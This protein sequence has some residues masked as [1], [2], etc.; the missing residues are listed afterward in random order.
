[1][2]RLLG[3][4]GLVCFVCGI[5]V[6]WLVDWNPEIIAIPVINIALGL[7]FIIIWFF[8][9]G[10][11]LFRGEGK[12]T[13]V[14]SAKLLSFS[15][16]YFVIVLGVIGLLNF[17]VSKYDWNFDLTRERIHT[18][19][20]KTV[21]LAKKI[22]DELEVVIPETEVTKS[23]IPFFRDMIEQINKHTDKVKLLVFNPY[24]KQTL[25]KDYEI[26]RGDAGVLVLRKAQ[27]DGK[28]GIKKVKLAS[29]TEA[30]FTAALQK[31]LSDRTGTLGYI[32]GH[33]EP[34]LEGPEPENLS[35]FVQQ[36]NRD[37]ISLKPISLLTQKS[38]PE[39]IG[40]L[41]LIGP[42]RP[43]S[44]EEIQLIIDYVKN[45]GRLLVAV[46]FF[47][48][49]ESVKK[50][51]SV[52]GIEVGNDIIIEPVQ[53]IGG[54]S[55]IAIN[56]FE[57]HP[58]TRGLNENKIIVGSNFSS[59]WPKHAVKFGDDDPQV[60][61]LAVA[62]T[63]KQSWAERGLTSRKTGQAVEVRYDEGTDV[64]G[65]IPVISVFNK[66]L[67]GPKKETKVVAFGSASMFNSIFF[68]FYFNVDVI[69]NSIN[70][71]LDY[72]EGE[73]VRPK[74]LVRSVS[75]IPE[76]SLQ[77]YFILLLL[78]PQFIFIFGLVIAWRRSQ[79]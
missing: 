71:L 66:Y 52:V 13:A 6:G 48:D 2:A 32:T 21:E 62:N 31:L 53:R 3:Q 72:D 43:L 73:A 45:G 1:M 75:P 50:I 19:S 65:P 11:P 64:I 15:T 9:V 25:V 55:D 24:A 22:Q 46:D 58:V 29:L 42:K 18:I 30:D 14:R 69:M 35:L 4:I 51:L 7:A 33:G 49:L 76:R 37:G 57:V 8:N 74:T 41:L 44:S 5:L 56:K 78:L 17:I 61:G 23:E 67:E 38:I 70:W 63:S 26:Q 39:E 60:I 20:E 27:K 34:A 10:I 77:K 40:A 36:L 59:V 16:F 54:P 47:G 68:P 12:T 79:A 28:E